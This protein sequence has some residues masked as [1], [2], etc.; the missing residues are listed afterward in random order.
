VD[1][2]AVVADAGLEETVVDVVF[3]IDC[4]SIRRVLVSRAVQVGHAGDVLGRTAGRPME[5][6]S[7]FI[8][9]RA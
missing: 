2:I 9:G 3:E 7:A 5:T 6:V 8:S 1:E 4:L